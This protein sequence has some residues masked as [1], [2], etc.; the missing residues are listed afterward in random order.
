MVLPGHVVPGV[1][2]HLE[3]GLRN[4]AHDGCGA[5]ANVRTGQQGAIEQCLQTVMFQHRGALDFAQKA[6][7]EDAFDGAAGVVGSQAEQ[8]GGVGGVRLQEGLQA[9]DAFP[10]AAQRIDV[11]FEGKLFHPA[12]IA[13]F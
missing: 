1:D 7:A 10:G 3:S 6:L 8:K 2:A 9:R 12:T 11:N 13:N 5:Q 4:R